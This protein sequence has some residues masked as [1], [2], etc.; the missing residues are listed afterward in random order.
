MKK[1]K[2]FNKFFQTKKYNDVCMWR[3]LGQVLWW[4]A[5]FGRKF[6]ELYLT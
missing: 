6:G 5:F 3:I 4:G 1:R 2:I